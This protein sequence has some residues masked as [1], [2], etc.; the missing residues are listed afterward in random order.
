[1]K[2]VVYRRYGPPDVLRIENIA[3]P[4]VGANDILVRVQAAEATKGDCEMR[5]FRFPVK[6]FQIPLRLAIGVFRPRK[7]VLGGYFAGEVAEVGAGVR[8]FEVGQRIFGAS[9]LLLGAYA[10]Y[11]VV[12]QRYTLARIPD[13]LTFA[14]AAA[15]PLG[16]LNA[17][18]CLT[19]AKVRPGEKVL[20]NGAGGSIGTFAVQIARSMGGEVTAVDAGFKESMLRSI[21]AEHFVDYQQHDIFA[22]ETRYDVIFDMVASTLHEH[23]LNLL[24][25]GGRYISANPTFRK[26]VRAAGVSKKTDKSMIVA[27]AGETIDELQRLNDLLENGQ[28]R[29]VIDRIFPMHEAA[30]AHKRVESEERIGIV[31]LSWSPDSG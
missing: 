28:I 15:V 31:V 10:E 1:L 9:K 26:L 5:S 7:S 8:N 3:R 18:H 21:G 13:E 2:A 4:R 16:G 6:W 27:F 29:P 12:P 14:E 23:A 11:L 20:V 19:S 22:G 17:L 24:N 25:S 30:A